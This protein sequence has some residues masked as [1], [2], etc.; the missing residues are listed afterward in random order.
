MKYYISVVEQR[1]MIVEV[2]AEELSEAI[3]KA[4]EAYD[5]DLISLDDPDTIDEG[6]HFLD[7]TD[8]W[9]KSAAEGLT[10]FQSIL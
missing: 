10:N 1:S 3:D 7:E 5:D 6:T 2:E 4:Q 8:K 9:A